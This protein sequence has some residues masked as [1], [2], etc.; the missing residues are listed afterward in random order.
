MS[1][2]QFVPHWVFYGI[3]AIG[4]LGISFSR[5]VPFYYRAAAQVISYLALAAGLFMTGAVKGSESLLADMKELKDKV[6]VAEQQSVK[7]TI[8]VETKST[9][10]RLFVS[11]AKMYLSILTVKL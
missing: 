1:Y 9:R 6:S 11:V 5:F 2:L 8:K 10:H 3:L 4:I 7:E